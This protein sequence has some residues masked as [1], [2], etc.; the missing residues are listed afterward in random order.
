MNPAEKV[1]ATLA[2][3]AGIIEAARESATRELATLTPEQ[4]TSQAFARYISFADGVMAE[5][6]LRANVI[7]RYANTVAREGFMNH[8]ESA[9]N[10]TEAQG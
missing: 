3:V 1:S 7:R 8:G 10:T 5:L 4:R 6:D 2:Y 9:D